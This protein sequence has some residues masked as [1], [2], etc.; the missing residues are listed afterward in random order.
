MSIQTRSTTDVNGSGVQF[1]ARSQA[2]RGGVEMVIGQT[3]M[4]WLSGVLRLNTLIRLPY[5]NAR[6]CAF[7]MM[8]MVSGNRPPNHTQAAVPAHATDR[9]GSSVAM[10][11]ARPYSV[12]AS[13]Y[14]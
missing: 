12:R 1:M 3:A 10:M 11:L 13:W 5:R 6:Q 2:V 8:S 14:V 4:T 9:L 7:A